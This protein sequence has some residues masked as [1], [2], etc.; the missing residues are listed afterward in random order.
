[1]L[2][3]ALTI[4]AATPRDSGALAQLAQLAG[5]DHLRGHALLAES[6]GSA[7]AAIALTNGSVVGHPLHATAD[8]LTQLRQ[9]RYG[10]IRQGGDVG[11]VRALLRRLAPQPVGI[12]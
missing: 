1:M 8:V 2:E 11:S 12:A 5:R 9:R 4:R 10:L 3:Q 7:I 6:D